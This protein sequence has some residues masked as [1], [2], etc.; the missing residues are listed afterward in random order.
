MNAERRLPLGRPRVVASPRIQPRSNWIVTPKTILTK[1]GDCLYCGDAFCGPEAI[2]LMYGAI[3]FPRGTP[4]EAEFSLMDYPDGARVKW[5]CP[6]CGFQHDV[7]G[8]E[9]IFQLSRRLQEMQKGWCCLC[10]QCIQPYPNADWSSAIKLELGAMGRSTKGD[11][12]RFYPNAPEGHFHWGCLE[13]LNL[14]LD[15]L[16]TGDDDKP[17]DPGDFYETGSY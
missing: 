4:Y 17:P 10:H 2:R 12:Y 13:D 7:L 16:I 11:F 14:D 3:T 6:D 15:S 5:L 8:G 9:K 1:I